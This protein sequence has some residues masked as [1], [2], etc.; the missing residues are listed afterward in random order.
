MSMQLRIVLTLIAWTVGVTL[1]HLAVNTHVL[2]F[3]SPPKN[4]KPFRV[5]F[6]P[7]T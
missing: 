1:L 6:L 2:E 4:E 7:V 5:G 3:G